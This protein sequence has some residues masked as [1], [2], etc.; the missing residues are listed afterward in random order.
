M[1]VWVLVA[2]LVMDS[3][4]KMMP[5]GAFV[6]MDE[7]FQARQAFMATGPQPKINYESVC[8]QTNQLEIL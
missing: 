6:S 2:I 5:L 1:N 7:C 8:I 4:F 3:N